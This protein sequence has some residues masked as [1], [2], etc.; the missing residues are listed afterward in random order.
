MA[1]SPKQEMSCVG[2]KGTV[3]SP[4]TKSV[5]F[6]YLKASVPRENEIPK[7]LL[8][9]PKQQPLTKQLIRQIANKSELEIAEISRNVDNDFCLVTKL[10]ITIPIIKPKYPPYRTYPQPSSKKTSEIKVNRD[11]PEV[12]KDDMEPS[13]KT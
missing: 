3:A 4:T 9:I 6:K 12:F 5:P 1:K 10:I 2:S 11:S 7:I 8:G 13:K